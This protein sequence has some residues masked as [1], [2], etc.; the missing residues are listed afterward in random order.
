MA[1]GHLEARHDFRVD[2][3]HGRRSDV[4]I[5]PVVNI[6]SRA[7]QGR[8]QTMRSPAR[9]D[10]KVFRDPEEYIDPKACQNFV[11]VD[12]PIQDMCTAGSSG[13]T[14]RYQLEHHLRRGAALLA[15]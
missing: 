3:E 11:T 12:S 14:I 5:S 8:T 4:Q 2:I 7:V 10:K 6:L 15:G 1:E 9:T 13:S